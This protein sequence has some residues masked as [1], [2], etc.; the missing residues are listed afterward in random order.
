MDHQSFGELAAKAL[1]TVTD[2]PPSSERSPVAK[3]KICMPETEA[4]CH[5]LREW[6]ET[7]SDAVP[8]ATPQQMAK[9]LGFLTATLPSKNIDED[10]AKLRF[11]VYYRILGEYSNAALA[12][13]SRKVCEEYDWFPTPHQCLEILA[14]YRPPVSDKEMALTLCR[15][16]WTEK[17]ENFLD[18]LKAGTCVQE[19][20]DGVPDQWRRIAAERGYLRR[21]PDGSYVVRQAVR[22]GDGGTQV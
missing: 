13:M 18:T 14:T 22:I 19:M 20:I 16:F 3:P 10:S 21:L 17:L 6:A 5:A 11:S 7:A 2:S 12:Y 4:E 15:H 9:H 8:A 1:A